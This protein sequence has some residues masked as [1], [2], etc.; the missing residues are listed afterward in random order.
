M[1]YES[2]SITYHTLSQVW[3]KKI[4]LVNKM[5][6]IVYEV[7]TVINQERN[8]AAGNIKKVCYNRDSNTIKTG[9][10][11]R[12][13]TPL[14]PTSVMIVRFLARPQVGKLVVACCWSAVYSSE[15]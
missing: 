15:P 1:P 8:Y 11:G 3:I 4:I 6:N 9:R 7:G 5:Q 10:G 14:P 2:Q 12:V 13:V